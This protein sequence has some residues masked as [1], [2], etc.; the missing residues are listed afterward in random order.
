MYVY[1]ILLTYIS[2]SDIDNFKQRQFRV[3]IQQKS[4]LNDV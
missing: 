1:L 2:L 4:R 3:S